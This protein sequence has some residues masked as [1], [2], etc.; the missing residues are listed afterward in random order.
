MRATCCSEQNCHRCVESAN[1]N[2]VV[3]VF[4]SFQHHYFSIALAESGP[5]T[6]AVAGKKLIFVTCLSSPLFPRIESCTLHKEQTN[7][8]FNAARG[9]AGFE[10]RAP[11][12]P[13]GLRLS[14]RRN[15]GDSTAWKP[16]RRKCFPRFGNTRP[17]RGDYFYF[18]E[19]HT[20]TRS[21]AIQLYSLSMIRLL[22]SRQLFAIRSVIKST[23]RIVECYLLHRES[24]EKIFLK[25][26]IQKCDKNVHLDLKSFF[27]G[28]VNHF[29]LGIGILYQ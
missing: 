28:V 4:K 21:D 25:I 13:P 12:P 29:L 1:N 20:S 14:L 27:N 5:A 19:H 6:A 10:K 8:F 23:H 17:T 9:A 3:M 2:T 24:F 18:N 16:V 11:R 7:S 26:T 15:A 22:L